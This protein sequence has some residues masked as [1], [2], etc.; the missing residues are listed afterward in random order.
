MSI[1]EKVG[2]W[3]YIA[4]DAAI[5]GAIV[6]YVTSKAGA[7]MRSGGRPKGAFAVHNIVLVAGGLGDFLRGAGVCSGA[8]GAASD[9]ADAMSDHA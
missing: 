7:I 4:M 9:G 3:V 5:V 1:S 8:G 2:T 6:W